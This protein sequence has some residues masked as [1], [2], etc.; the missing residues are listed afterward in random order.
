MGKK[1]LKTL[2]EI[3][4]EQYPNYN[5]G[6]DILDYTKYYDKYLPTEITDFLEIGVGEGYSIF[7]FKDWYKANSKTEPKFHAMNMNWDLGGVPAIETLQSKGIV[8]YECDQSNIEILNTI[9]TQ[10]D[11]IVEDG[12]HH[13]DDQI[14]TFK[15]MFDKNIKSGGV[16]ILE[17]LHCCLQPYWYRTVQGYEN[18]IVPVFEKLIRGE[19]ITSQYFTKQESDYFSSIIKSVHLEKSVD[20][21]TIAFIFKK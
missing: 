14:W 6:K 3:L 15:H 18:T 19:D 9:E 5:G 4:K 2:G 1:L 7:A 13:S 20:I 21:Q 16:Y 12:S 10:F 11:V 17:D 8:C